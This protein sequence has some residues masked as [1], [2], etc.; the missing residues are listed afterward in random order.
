L[1]GVILLRL[2]R[3]DEAKRAFG[4]ALKLRPDHPD[5]KH[6]LAL[7]ED[8]ERRYGGEHAR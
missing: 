3:L 6:N 5:A 7:L 1:A 2:G 4:D 8:L